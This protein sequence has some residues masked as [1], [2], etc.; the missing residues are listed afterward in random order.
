M[1]RLISS[2]CQKWISLVCLHVG[3]SFAIIGLHYWFGDKNAKKLCII[4]WVLN[5][6]YLWP[7]MHYLSASGASYQGVLCSRSPSQQSP[8]KRQKCPLDGASQDTHISLTSGQFRISEHLWG[9]PRGA[10]GNPRRHG[11][12]MQTQQTRK[13]CICVSLLGFEVPILSTSIEA[14]NSVE[15]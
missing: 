6:Q 15:K 12:N 11:Q 4:Q 2:T 1:K 7:T 13:T 8:G 5:D 14:K 10:G 9:E 3:K